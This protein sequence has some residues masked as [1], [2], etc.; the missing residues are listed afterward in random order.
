MPRRS[1]GARLWLRDERRDAG[2][3]KVTHKATW[4]IRDGS[5]FIGTGCG[6]GDRAGAEKRLA[7]YIQQK[8]DP[9]ATRGG[10]PDQIAV[11]DVMNIYLSEVAPYKARPQ[12]IAARAVRLIEWFGARTLA[13]LGER[14]C[15]AYADSRSS[16]NAARREL[17]DLRAAIGHYQ[18]DNSINGNVPSVWLPPKP[19][20]RQRWLT[21]QEAAK[22]L[23]NLW[24][25]RDPLTGENTRRHVARYFIVSLYTGTRSAAV[26][27]AAI[28]PAIGQGYVDLETGHFYRKT[29]DKSE[30]RN[31]RQPT[32]ILP[33]RVLAHVR[34]WHRLG[35][36]RKHVVEY[37]GKPVK[38]VK[39]AWDAARRE[40]GLDDVVRHT[41]RH[42]AAT[43]LMQ[44]RTDR[45]E[46]AGY[47]GM[48]T[49][50]LERTYGHHHPDFQFTAARNITRAP[51]KRHSKKGTKAEHDDSKHNLS[52]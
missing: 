46:A 7:E 21:R 37:R 34:R 20:P 24:R 3:G 16:L 48:S 30:T 15:R 41:L 2:T 44:Q 4:I 22:F 32:C 47:L 39:K 35:L 13:D 49:E 6:V 28:G 12:E 50:T 5:R 31:K 27:N 9:R 51:Q 8:H 10:Y 33:P 40:T 18:R 38:S 26:L 52:H 42:T 29:R 23:R 43:W 36:S 1:E 25:A 11:A 19:Q 14:A 17:E 45:W